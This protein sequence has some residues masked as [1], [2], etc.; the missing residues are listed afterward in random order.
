MADYDAIVVGAG[1]NGLTCALYLAHAG[2]RVL[3]LERDAEIGGG[4]RTAEVTLPGFRHDLYATNLTL[5]SKS[6]VIAEFR[7][8]FEQ[9][10][11]RFVSNGFPYASAYSGG[12]CA[13]VYKDSAAT[14]REIA[15][16]S[17]EDLAGWRDTVALFQRTAAR[18]LPLFNAA[19]PSADALGKIARMAAAGPLDALRVAGIFWQTPRQFGDR[20]FATEAVKGLFAPWSFHLDY[21]PDVH[22]GAMFSFINGMSAHLG[23]LSVVE[24]GAAHIPA[25][26]RA[27]IEA[28][29]GKIV[30]GAE[31]TRIRVEQ[32]RAVAVDTAAGDSISA[33]RAI[34]AEVAP[35]RLFGGLV[36]AHDLPAGFMLRVRR[37][38]Y[39]VG[40][41]VVHLALSE[42]LQWRAAED[43]AQFNYVHIC[44]ATRDIERT[45]AESL[46]GLLPARPMLI[47]SQ[48]TQVDP[49]RAPAG[50]HVARLHVRAA[51]R[52]VA[53]DAAGTIAGRDWREIKEPF[54]DRLLD[55]V[56]EHAPNVKKALLARHVVSTA[57][58]ESLNPNFVAGDCNGGSHHPDQNFLCRPFFGWSRYATPIRGLYQASA[59]TWPGGGVH[60]AAGQLIARRLTAGAPG[61]RAA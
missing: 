50:R 3:V 7:A 60:G 42:P 36:A 44:G 21:G 43:L 31:V 27:L 13:R 26:F 34:V 24:G 39:G 58:L 14:E 1:H 10:G 33:G 15:R 11:V 32:G 4:M 30:T 28:R 8:E 47:F 22:G 40:T 45:Y 18:F 6:P 35:P 52:H 54:A 9:A 49:T 12:T 46:A 51:P 41:F 5:F 19:L 56:A 23:G 53:G 17:A 48:T 20:R 29:G 2:W 59:A 37:Y 25:A 55:L 61:A 57:D 16:H 38:R